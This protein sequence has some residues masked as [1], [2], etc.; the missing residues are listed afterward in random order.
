M[1]IIRKL[2]FATTK[3]W[4]ILIKSVFRNKLVEHEVAGLV[5][6][7]LYLTEVLLGDD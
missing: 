6:V 1:G 5:Q 2:I 3:T 4:N 7:L